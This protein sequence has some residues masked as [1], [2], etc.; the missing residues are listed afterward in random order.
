VARC[1]DGRR[2]S[3]VTGDTDWRDAAGALAELV[4]SFVGSPAV[5]DRVV[6]SQ[7]GRV[8]TSTVSDGTVSGSSSYWYD[9]AGR[10]VRAVIP[11]H[12]LSYEF[13]ASGGCGANPRAG[14]NGNRTSSRDVLDGGAV[15]TVTSCFDHADRL[16]STTVTDPPEG[17]SPISRSVAGSTIT[18]DGAGSTTTLAGQ[19]FGYDQAD[20]HVSSTGGDGTVVRYRRDAADRVVERAQAVGG[21][22]SVTRFA[23][24][25]A[26]GSP[27]LVLDGAGAVL[28]RTLSLPG[29]VVVSLP[30]VGEA[31]W[32]YPNVHGDVVAAAD[33]G[34]VRSGGLAWFDPFGQP[35]DPVSGLIGTGVADDA[36]V[37]NVPGEADWG[38]V[39][40]HQRLYEHA[41]ELAAVEMGAR[42]FVP[43]LGR[44]LSVDP[45]EGGVDNAYVYPT[46]PVNDYD[47]DGTFAFAAPL[48]PALALGGSNFW[49][50]VGWATLAVIT[51]AVV[52]IGV[53]VVYKKASQKGTT[54]KGSRR[55]KNTGKTYGSKEEATRAARDY[56]NKHPQTCRYRGEC[57]SGDHVHVDKSVRGSRKTTTRHY[58]W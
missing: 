5:S 27:D 12:D 34:G 23:F 40:Q 18:Y 19:R 49:N 54:A 56:A 43:G 44:F 39:G 46:D 31:V 45:V 24:T 33:G 1:D 55:E 25:G 6:R 35:V 16:T 20:R 29:G 28:A 7:S 42:V 2:G 10:L 48:L 11:R 14:L 36:V 8:L 3:K 22:E 17:A 57:A 15:T 13:A 50:P 53:A 32:S 30:V 58:Y 4:W 9:G 26:G 51:V 38:W 47:L 21:A 52:A 37:D 41:G